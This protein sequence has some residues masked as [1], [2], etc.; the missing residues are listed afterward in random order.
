[1]SEPDQ[2]SIARETVYGPSL[3]DLLEEA[4]DGIFHLMPDGRVLSV[5]A[6]LARM[7]GYNAPEELLDTV[8]HFARQFFVFPE[9]AEDLIR[10]LSAAGRV[11][12][13]EL[14]LY[15]RNGAR[16]W[17]SLYAHIVRDKENEPLYFEGFVQD[18]TARKQAQTQLERNAR[19]LAALGLMG[20]TVA[21]SLDQTIVLKRVLDEVLFLLSADGVSVLLL[22][23]DQL[24]VAAVGGAGMVSLIGQRMS[25]QLGVAGEVVRTGQSALIHDKAGQARIYQPLEHYALAVQSLIAAPLKLQG[26]II[27][28]IEAVHEDPQAFVQE[29]LQMLESAASWAAIAIGNAR[30]HARI[31]RRLQES[32]AMAVIS[33]ALNESH[34]LEHILQTIV[35]AA[36]QIIAQVEQAIIHL[37]DENS[38][39]LRAAAVSS[40]GVLGRSEVAMRS[41]E[42]IA[43]RV[44]AEGLPIN[45]GDV[46]T[47]SRY[48]PSGRP[49]HLRSLMVAPVQSGE[50][51]LG[52]ISVQSTAAYAFSDDDE[53]LLKTLGLQAALAIEN[54]RL[55]AAESAAREEAEVLSEIGRILSSTLNFDE[56]LDRLLEQIGRLVPY[57][58]AAL[59]LVEP[60]S[61]RARVA[62]LRGYEQLSGE[63]V[64]SV[65]DLVLEIARIPNLRRMLETRRPHTVPDVAADPTWVS[66]GQASGHIRSWVGAPIE[67]QGEGVV[68]FFSLDKREPNFYTPEHAQKL[69]AFA[70]QASLAIQ[71]AR[72]FADLEKSLQYEKSVRARMVQTEKL[73]A[74]GRLVASVAHELNNPLQAIQNSLYLVSQEANLAPQS[75]EDLQVALT[76]ADRMADLI[77]R[78]RETYRPASAEQFRPESLNVVIEEV[79][80]LIGTHLR[81]NNIAFE[82]EPARPLP[83]VRGLRDQLKQVFLNLCLNAVEAMPQGGA[84]RLRTRARPAQGEVEVTVSDTGAGIDPNDQRSIFEPFFTKK[85]GGTGLGLFITYEIIQR[86]HGRIEVES[87]V[88][89]GT[90]FHIWLPVAGAFRADGEPWPEAR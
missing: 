55:L 50:R 22:E 73:A 57:D 69:G 4:V 39:L 77:G 28:V 42:G 65:R 13:V 26:Q 8:P 68:A 46:H 79:Q 63:V 61:S 67:L 27:G 40:D 29:D 71:N 54:A 85:E 30:Q 10:H 84:L 23:R 59:M 66:T 5:N 15:R 7:F 64:Q 37:V 78:L 74:M 9:Q 33:Q 81:H 34:E 75:R 86:H 48:L 58:T 90:T 56:V 49:L 45:V 87:H 14:Q 82:F 83:E 76:E 44:M 31:Q 70:G 38:P 52:T 47:D 17:V 1:V 20:Q 2:P 62:R 32:E 24:A 72:L 35:D 3:F 53:Q 89:Q 80:K 60:A 6:A 43:G 21:S 36:R 19:Q 41:G 11:R 51:R 16:F 88:G 12:G 25:V 18:I